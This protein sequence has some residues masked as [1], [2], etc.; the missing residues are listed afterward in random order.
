MRSIRVRL[1]LLMA[2]G[3]APS[4]TEAQL[5]K[6]FVPTARNAAGQ[7]SSDKLTQE[8][9]PWL[10]VAASFSGVGAE[11]QAHELAAELRQRHRLTS[12]VH[13]M[14]F[15]LSNKSDTSPGRGLDQYG[16]PIRRRY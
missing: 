10:I 16:A 13:E 1:M 11:E 3:F 4:T 6:H 12:Y 14:S 15:D 5:W 2:V 7:A 9:G 8:S